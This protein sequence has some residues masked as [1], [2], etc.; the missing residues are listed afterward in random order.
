MSVFENIS[1][2]LP[3]DDAH[4]VY[5]FL[6]GSNYSYLDYFFIGDIHA[7]PNMFGSFA[8]QKS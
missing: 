5:I 4:F 7:V 3:I 6:G 1:F 8:E 2:Y